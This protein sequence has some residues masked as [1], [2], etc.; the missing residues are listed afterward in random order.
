M[1]DALEA[2]TLPSWVWKLEIGGWGLQTVVEIL[3]WWL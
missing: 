2:Q 3:C 1:L